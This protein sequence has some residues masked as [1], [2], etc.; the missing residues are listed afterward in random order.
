MRLISIALLI[1]ATFTSCTCQLT[2]ASQSHTHTHTHTHTTRLTCDVQNREADPEFLSPSHAPF[3]DY[4][5]G[6][7]TPFGEQTM[8]YARSLVSEGK[9]DPS[10]IAAAYTA[11]YTPPLNTSRRF[12]S[13]YDN[14]TKGFLANVAAGRTWPH[15]GDGDTETNA[16]A[17]VLPVV[18]R[19][20]TLLSML[21]GG[22]HGR[23]KQER[24]GHCMMAFLDS[25][26]FLTRAPFFCR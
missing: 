2:R 8:V 15:T 6:E 25:H 22:C 7:F 10:A 21:R 14:A 11:Y 17:H 16:V 23:D 3:Y 19:E 24:E 26:T 12:N 13:Y 1:T 9:V 18:V 4:P 5:V 20:P